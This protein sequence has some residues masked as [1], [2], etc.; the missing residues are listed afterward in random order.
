MRNNWPNQ[1]FI[2]GYS[3]VTNT[4]CCWVLS[5]C[6]HS[7]KFFWWPDSQQNHFNLLCNRHDDRR[8]IYIPKTLVSFCVR[9]RQRRIRRQRPQHV[10]QTRTKVFDQILWQF[11]THPQAFEFFSISKGR[12]TVSDTQSHRIRSNW[13]TYFFLNSFF[14]SY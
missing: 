12:I 7:W 10:E 4:L 13:W 6:A 8:W 2:C 11:P 14:L 1:R 3:I 9:R 5:V